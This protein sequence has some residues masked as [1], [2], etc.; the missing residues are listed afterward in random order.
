MTQPEI[1]GR[2]HLGG[3][4]LGLTNNLPR[5]I[6]IPAIG[7]PF[8]WNF[9][10]V[11]PG[12]NPGNWLRWLFQTSAPMS[13]YVQIGNAAQSAGP[14]VGDWWEWKIPI[15]TVPAGKSYNIYMIAANGPNCGKTRQTIDGV[16]NGPDMDTYAA[17]G[18]PWGTRWT[19]GIAGPSPAKL[20][21]LR[22]TVIAK[23]AASTDTFILIAGIA[24]GLY[25]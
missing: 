17:A 16:T 6:T 3:Q 21:T 8:N 4:P 13:G 1:V 20:I 19:G 11:N 25:D 7:Q 18:Y 9:G 14:A 10:G 23:N 15:P 22:S 5:A 2:P 12:A 24:G